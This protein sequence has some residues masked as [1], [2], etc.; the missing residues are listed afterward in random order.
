VWCGRTSSGAPVGFCH[1]PGS[2]WRHLFF[3]HRNLLKEK[4]RPVA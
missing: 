2:G 4:R 3:G 1:A